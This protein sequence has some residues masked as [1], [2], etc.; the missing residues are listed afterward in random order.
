[1]VWHVDRQIVTDVSVK[2]TAYICRMNKTKISLMIPQNV[3]HQ[4]TWQNSYVQYITHYTARD[5][6]GTWTLV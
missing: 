5:G 2:C 4:L 1:M 6:E 3:A